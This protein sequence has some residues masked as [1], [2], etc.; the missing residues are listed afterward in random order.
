MLCAMISFV[1]NRRS[2]C[3]RFTRRQPPPILTGSDEGHSLDRSEWQCHKN[4]ALV[5]RSSCLNVCLLH[6][7]HL[8][9]L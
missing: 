1:E 6:R 2:Y 8:F 9:F 4:A 5:N 3:K 7:P